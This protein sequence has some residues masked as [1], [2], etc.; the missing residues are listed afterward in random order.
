MKG[1]LMQVVILLIMARLVHAENPAV[2]HLNI[3][4]LP[5]KVKPLPGPFTLNNQTR[6]LAVAKESRRNRRPL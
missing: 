6:V 5:V 1:H 3:V 4:P 2:P